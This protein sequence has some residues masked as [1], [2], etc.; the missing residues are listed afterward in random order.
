MS[1]STA[2]EVGDKDKEGRLVTSEMSILA[3]DAWLHRHTSRDWYKD[4][5]LPPKAKAGSAHKMTLGV[6]D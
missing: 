3:R 5:S 1:V 6:Q 4:T 2:A